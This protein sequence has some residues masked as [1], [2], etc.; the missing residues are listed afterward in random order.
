MPATPTTYLALQKPD[1]DDPALVTVLNA[2][3]DE[4][5]KLRRAVGGPLDVNRGFYVT[6]PWMGPV[7]SHGMGIGVAVEAPP[8]G[9]ST[10]LY[11]DGTIKSAA[12][13][14]A[15]GIHAT[16]MIQ[17]NFLAGAAT[18]DNY[19]GVF[20]RQFTC[21]PGSLRAAGLVVDSPIGGG[22][23]GA[24]NYSIVN[25]GLIQMRGASGI[26]WEQISETTDSLIAASTGAGVYVPGSAAGDLV[27]RMATGKKL[28]LSADGGATAHAVLTQTNLTL[29][30]P[31]V[32]PA[33]V[34]GGA[35]LRIPHGVAPTSP[36]NGDA[37]TTTAGLFV[38]INGATVGPLS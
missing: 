9:D 20:I 18:V 28:Y 13:G 37:W 1:L 5:D 14:G 30:L 32:L 6:G 34:T 19:E 38:R 15:H 11:V 2:N 16:V 29:A 26:L 31:L 17:P 23:A 25:S 35:P 33:G 21:P 27:V 7:V 10:Q 12:S 24:V 8:G 4:I 3:F 36:V 22:P